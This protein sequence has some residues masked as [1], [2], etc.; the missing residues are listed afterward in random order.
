M[1]LRP[2]SARALRVRASRSLWRHLI[3]TRSPRDSP[4]TVP[5]IHRAAFDG[6][7][8]YTK[9]TSTDL[10]TLEAKLAL[11]GVNDYAISS[12]EWR[13]GVGAVAAPIFDAFSAPAAAIGISG[14]LKRLS[15]KPMKKLTPAVQEAAPKILRAMGYQR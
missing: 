5:G 7:T 14:P 15:V 9:A 10:Q 12:G 13:D 2:P 3:L 6:L 1:R 4:A 8:A 11:A